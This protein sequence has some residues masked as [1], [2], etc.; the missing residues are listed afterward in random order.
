[1][2]VECSEFIPELSVILDNLSIWLSK[3]ECYLSP[4]MSM[5][6]FFVLCSYIGIPLET[7]LSLKLVHIIIPILQARN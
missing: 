6:V 3:K 4:K 5:S 7:F 2:C 1:M